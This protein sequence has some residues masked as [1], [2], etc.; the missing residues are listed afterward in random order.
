MVLRVLWSVFFG[1]EVGGCDQDWCSTLHCGGIRGVS[2]LLMY[3]MQM[4]TI[5]ALRDRI[6]CT[7]QYSHSFDHKVLKTA[8][9]RL[10]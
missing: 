2:R 5:K 9:P 8:Q 7:R 6:R 10:K 4:I 3:L 1:F